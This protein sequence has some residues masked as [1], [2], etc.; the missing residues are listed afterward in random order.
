MG[1]SP[2]LLSNQTLSIIHAPTRLPN[3]K[4]Y[5]I[6]NKVETFSL[7]FIKIW[8]LQVILYDERD[9]SVLNTLSAI[10]L[11]YIKPASILYLFTWRAQSAK[12]LAKCCGRESPSKLAGN[13]FQFDIFEEFLPCCDHL[14]MSS[15]Q[16]IKIESKKSETM[17]QYSQVIVSGIY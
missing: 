13:F 6:L 14:N 8:N 12:F 16:M 15:E 10:I 17:T 11:R 9:Q 1:L 7:V 3:L 5:K 4:W 2:F